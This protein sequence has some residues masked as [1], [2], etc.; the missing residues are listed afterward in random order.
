MYCQNCYFIHN[1]TILGR[2]LNRP[3]INLSI[4]RFLFRGLAYFLGLTLLFMITFGYFVYQRLLID[5]P[6]I[7]KLKNVHYEI[8]LKIY[9]Q[10][11]LLIGQFGEQNRFPI[12]L[13]EVPQTLIDAFLAA[14]DERFFEHPGVDYKGL[15]RAAVQLIVT[16][17]KRQGGSTITM[18]VIRNFLLS[19]EK[20][21]IRKLKEIILAIKFENEYSKNRILELYLNQIYLGHRSYGVFAAAQTYY[22]KPLSALSLAETAMIAGLPK[23]PSA[24][25]PIANVSRALER[26]NYVLRRM[27]ELNFISQNDYKNGINQPSTAQVQPTVIDLPAPYLAEMARQEILQRYGQK[28]YSS[29]LIV[30]TTINSTLQIAANNALAHALHS[31]DERHGFRIKKLPSLQPDTEL[32]EIP[33]VGDTIPAM[34]IRNSG[35]SISARLADNTEIDISEENLNWAKKALGTT[36][37]ERDR[38]QGKIVRVRQLPDLQWRIAQIP[39]AEG[40]FAA[41]NPING[42]IVAMTGGFDFDRNKF[43]RAIQS[44]RQPGS[45]FKP[46]IYAA[47]LEEG[48]TPASL[49]ND[50]PIVIESPNQE[51]EWRP[52]NYNRKFLGPTTLRKALTHS[53]NII[54]IRLLKEIGIEKAIDTAERFG[55]KNQQLPKTLSLA[56]GSGYASPLQMAQAYAVFANGGFLVQPYL[57]ERIETKEGRVLFQAEPKTACS[58]CSYDELKSGRYAPKIL[59]SDVAFLMN[60]LLRDV[61]QKGTA[62]DAKILARQDL[63]GKTGTT[64]DY[65]DAWFNGYSSV[66]SASAWVGYDNFK[67]LGNRETGG[68]TALPMWIEFMKTAMANIPETP[69]TVPDGIEE[70][71]INPHS[72]QRIPAGSKLGV[73]EYFPEGFAPELIDSSEHNTANDEKSRGHEA[74][75]HDRPLEALF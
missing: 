13:S 50:E 51:N 33:N 62:T 43:N 31:Y 25:N 67:S 57:I 60:S 54:S 28:A 12:P 32:V 41:V 36:S 58:L 70:V 10:D 23:A 3:V 47:A 38:L 73:I 27:L 9:S 53:R 45:G 61:V 15:I 75:S 46:I 68:K 64:N 21:Y 59:A 2:E 24:Y 69:L 44:K 8:P 34:I 26:R 66:I 37:S 19:N 20:T 35:S 65:R 52:E 17:K 16:G 11:D 39:Q 74:I 29:G 14:E 56:L 71:L 63:A 40:A 30:H 18:Q 42:A 1:L 6:D 5:L 49:I 72:G 7:G 55:F 22:G 4:F 48:F